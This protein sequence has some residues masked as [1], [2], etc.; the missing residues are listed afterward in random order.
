[1]RSRYAAELLRTLVEDHRDR[2]ALHAFVSRD[3]AAAWRAAPGAERVRWTTL[4]VRMAGPPLHLLASYAA[5]PA[6]ALG[7]RLDV[8][9]APA[10]AGAVRVP[11]APNVAERSQSGV[12]QG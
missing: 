1:M 9:H 4:P 3:G 5:I 8:L 6:L 10:N 11:G 7:R 2:I 12:S